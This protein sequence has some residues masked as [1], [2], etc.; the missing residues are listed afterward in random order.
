MPRL[1]LSLPSGWVAEAMKALLLKGMPDSSVSLVADLPQA[2]EALGTSPEID[3]LVW[4]PVEHPDVRG[5]LRHIAALHSRLPVVVLV[6][7]R[8]ATQEGL[9]LQAGARGVLWAG[10]SE[11]AV[12]EAVRLVLRGGTHNLPAATTAPTHYVAQNGLHVPPSV[13]PH[14]PPPQLRRFRLTARQVEVLQ[15]IGEGLTNKTIARR[16]G[17]QEGTVKVHLRQILRQLGVRNRT[18][19]ALLLRDQPSETKQA[20][21][22]AEPATSSFDGSS[23]D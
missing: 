21:I 10:M 17:L 9:F 3:L 5:A 14:P 20:Y 19:A 13:L 16:L 18:Q 7:R 2:L 22:A 11:S 4:A 15:L 12:L 1:L 23:R 6:P 8:N